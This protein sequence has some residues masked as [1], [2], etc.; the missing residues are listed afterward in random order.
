MD[1]GLNKKGTHIFLWQKNKKYK[2]KCN[3]AQILKMDIL[4]SLGP[5]IR[6]RHKYYKKVVIYKY[7]KSYSWRKR[8]PST[9]QEPKAKRREED[10][11]DNIIIEIHGHGLTDSSCH[12]GPTSD[13]IGGNNL[14]DGQTLQD[15][16]HLLLLFLLQ[17]R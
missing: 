8:I 3:G 14:S 16:L 4:E 9:K 12:P 1:A 2:Y 10:Q 15:P 17:T 6:W 13:P 11:E 7:H 5:R